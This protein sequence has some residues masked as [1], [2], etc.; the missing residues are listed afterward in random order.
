[1]RTYFQKAKSFVLSHKIWSAIILI[2]ALFFGHSIYA[3]ITNTA[4]E[5]R[6]IIGKVEKGSIVTSV[7]GTGQ[8]SATSQIDIKPKVS[9][10]VVYI[11]TKNGA[12]VNAGS[13]ILEIDP[14][15]AQKAVRDAEVSLASAKLSLEKLKIQNSAEN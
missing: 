12:K 14:K 11:A 3:K 15:D 9:G 6:Y 4:G 7:S 5:T 2:V 1:M 13:L 10:D 8:V